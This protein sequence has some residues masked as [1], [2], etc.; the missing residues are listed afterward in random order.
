MSTRPQNVE[1]E[2]IDA[3]RVS[4]HTGYD[5]L[6]IRAEEFWSRFRTQVAIRRPTGFG[7]EWTRGMYDVLHAVQLDLNVWCQCRPGHEP[8]QGAKGELLKIDMMWFERT[9]RRWDPPLVAIEHE[10][11]WTVDAARTDFWRV[12]QICAPLCQLADEGS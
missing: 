11:A 8:S 10:N 3:W 2:L 6:M 9:D 4:C 7:A 1:A 5:R 12:C